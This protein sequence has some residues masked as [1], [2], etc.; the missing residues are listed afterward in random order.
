MT[1]AK[2]VQEYI[3]VSNVITQTNAF[4]VTNFAGI[5]I[6]GSDGNKITT[7]KDWLGDLDISTWIT[8]I[9]NRAT[10]KKAAL[11]AEIIDILNSGV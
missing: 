2:K 1:L 11:K 6:A 10:Q 9:R 3:E 5:E 7:R 4:Q 8:V